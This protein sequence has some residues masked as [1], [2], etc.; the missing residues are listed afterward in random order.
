MTRFVDTG[1]GILVLL[2][3][4]V[5]V[6]IVDIIDDPGSDRGDPHPRPIVVTQAGIRPLHI[7]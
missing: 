7:R 4:V 2:I 6:P 5:V 1:V 3:V